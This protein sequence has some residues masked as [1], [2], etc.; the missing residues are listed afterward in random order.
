MPKYETYLAGARWGRDRAEHPGRLR[1]LGGVFTA[2]RRRVHVQSPSPLTSP[3]V[4]SRP[5]GG[6]VE[7]VVLLVGVVVLLLG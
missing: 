7:G 2:A 5:G 1:V 4:R 3:T 6:Q